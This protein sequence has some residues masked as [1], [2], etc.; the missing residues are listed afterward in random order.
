MEA[1]KIQEKYE[2]ITKQKDYARLVM[3]EHPPKLKSEE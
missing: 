2:T 3:E 1:S